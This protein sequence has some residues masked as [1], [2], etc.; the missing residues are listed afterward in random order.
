MRDVLLIG[1]GHAH[2][3]LAAAGERFAEADARLT[4]VDPGT[5]WYSGAATGMLAGQYDRS[6]DTLDP[7]AVVERHGGRFV[8]DRVERLDLG[9]HRAVLAS[10]A[11]LPFDVASVNVGSR[12]NDGGVAGAAEHAVPVKPIAG[13]WDL[14][15]RLEQAVSAGKTG[16][17]PRV[18]VIGGGF[19]GCE[20]AASVA[21]LARGRGGRAEVT[22]VGR[23]KQLIDGASGRAARRLAKALAR[24][25]VRVVTGV[26]VDA[27]EPGE[28]VTVSGGRLP[29]D[30]AILATGLRP[31]PELETFG[32]RLRHG[33][34]AVDE[35]LRAH[36]SPPVFAA[37]DCITWPARPLPKLGVYGV[38]AAPV[39]TDNLIAALDGQPT[40]AY[41][42]Q[43]SW[44][45]IINLG[46]GTAMLVSNRG[47]FW[48]GRSMMWLKHR[49]D[50]KWLDQYR[51]ADDDLH[52]S[53]G[54]HA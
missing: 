40:R 13:L 21:E 42:P 24:R 48:T 19:T 30:H 17:P 47:V 15:Q 23:S 54:G 46:R 28:A 53:S 3:A 7:R 11:S 22:L 39:L 10:G 6:F 41:R 27:I 25:R 34:I 49:L 9:E 50:S 2:L 18:L 14:R 8:A 44:F 16:R 20:V 12:V 51:V 5:F 45:T 31:P 35:H 52:P 29:F 1:A 38:K 33:G 4:L 36:Q 43:R 32:L 37:G 26:V